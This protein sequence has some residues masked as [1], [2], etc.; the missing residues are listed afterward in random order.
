MDKLFQLLVFCAIV[1]IGIYFTFPYN[2]S[3]AD[4][5]ATLKS[6]SV[7][8]VLTVGGVMIGIC[9]GFFLA[10]LRMLHIKIINFFID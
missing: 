2:L 7:T 1:G 9:V 8:L 3:N 5:Y 4:L 6:I 10:F